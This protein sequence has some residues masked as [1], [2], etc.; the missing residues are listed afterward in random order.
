VH[1]HAYPD[2]G[3]DRAYPTSS[4]ADPIFPCRT[5]RPL[6]P[7]FGGVATPGIWSRLEAPL[8]AALG[9]LWETAG[10]RSRLQPHHWAS[11]HYG[12]IALNAHGW[13]VLQAALRGTVP[14]PTLIPPPSARIGLWLEEA[15]RR[16]AVWRRRSVRSRVRL[17]S[18]EVP[19]TLLLASKKVPEDLEAL[20]LA[21]G[22]VD[23]R[24]WRELVFLWLAE[25][26]L[27]S[28]EPVAETHARQAL[29]L[30]R[31]FTRLF[32]ERLV[33]RGALSRPADAA[34]LTFEERLVAATDPA[35]P[36][37]VYLETRLKRVEEFVEVGVPEVFWGSP[38]VIDPEKS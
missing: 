3:E 24:T 2:R 19:E 30:E 25:S 21:R 31:R 32:G 8:G 35:G 11:I 14:D 29:Q 27:E 12:R 36:W 4:P 9:T 5:L 20:E 1:R 22:P 28:T 34:Y 18:H 26:L 37:S 23:E 38:R 7:V 15:R 10:L 16:L 17:A 6:I 13:E 33:E